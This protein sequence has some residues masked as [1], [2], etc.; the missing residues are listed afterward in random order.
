MDLDFAHIKPDL[1]NFVILSIMIFVIIAFWKFAAQ[2]FNF[3]EPIKT[4]IGVA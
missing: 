4:V 3:P 1:I 2:K